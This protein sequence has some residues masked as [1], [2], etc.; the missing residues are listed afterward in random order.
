MACNFDK[1]INGVLQ[2]AKIGDFKF[3]EFSFMGTF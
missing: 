3:A 1:N 2:L